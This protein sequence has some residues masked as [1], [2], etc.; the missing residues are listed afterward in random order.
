MEGGAQAFPDV[1]VKAHQEQPWLS[2]SA[3]M[4][5]LQG[6]MP[7]VFFP[8]NTACYYHFLSPSHLTPCNSSPNHRPV[9]PPRPHPDTADK[10]CPKK[11]GGG[12]KKSVSQSHYSSVGV[13]RTADGVQN[14]IYTLWLSCQRC[15]FLFFVFKF[16]LVGPENNWFHHMTAEKMGNE[17]PHRLL[18]SWL[19]ENNTVRSNRIGQDCRCQIKKQLSD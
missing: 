17:K 1:G 18:N 7:L 8:F 9:N 6:W 13:T 10:G 4:R 11:P 5:G 3:L 16:V 15:C 19:L 14:S 2:W 12:T